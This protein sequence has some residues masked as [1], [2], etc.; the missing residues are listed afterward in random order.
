MY[1]CGGSVETRIGHMNAKD[2]VV[3]DVTL[4][5]GANMI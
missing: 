5:E 2:S 4:K 1:E 3:S